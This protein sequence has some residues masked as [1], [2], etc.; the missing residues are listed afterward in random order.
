MIHT[1]ESEVQTITY[2]KKIHEIL[3]DFHSTENQRNLLIKAWKMRAELSLCSPKIR[4]ISLKV[5]QIFKFLV[6]RA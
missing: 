6:Q 3:I 5:F 4:K 2:E 1:S